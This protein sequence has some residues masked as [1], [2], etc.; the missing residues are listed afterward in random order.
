M[1]SSEFLKRAA[2]WLVLRLKRFIQAFF[3]RR[4]P[5]VFLD[6]A[7]EWR[8]PSY[9]VRALRSIGDILI[10]IPQ[11]STS[12]MLRNSSLRDFVQRLI[13]VADDETPNA[14][15]IISRNADSWSKC[16]RSRVHVSVDYFAPNREVKALVMPYFIHPRL[17]RFE[18]EFARPWNRNRPIRIGFA[19]T[20]NDKA[21]TEVFRFPIMSRSE[22][23]RTL[24]ARFHDCIQFVQS[25]AEYARAKFTR[26][27][28]IIV[29]VEREGDSLKKHILNGREYLRFLANC[30]FF[31]APPGFAMPFAHNLIEA[32][33]LGAI[34]ILNYASYLSP[35]LRNG[36][37]CLTF[38]TPDELSQII[39]RALTMA[40]DEIERLR[41][42]VRHYVDDYLSPV[43]FGRRLYAEVETSPT[44]I[45]NAEKE[46]L[47]LWSEQ[48]L[49]AG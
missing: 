16:A 4:Q 42:G 41:V 31:I 15:I 29:A 12:F 14:K 22:M 7:N 47:T 48:H 49:V 2:L 25:R 6:C 18:R 45:V 37:D 8:Y 5:D 1:D 19:G 36:I 40:P 46:S 35:P 17:W 3:P 9:L 10:E 28:I 32:M 21:Y 13:I 34:P 30:A 43:A 38:S 26:L 11:S 23:F 20:I 24:N 33:F 39:D 27:P 44:I